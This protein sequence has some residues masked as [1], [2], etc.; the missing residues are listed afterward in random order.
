MPPRAA[1]ATRQFARTET[2]MPMKPAAADS[3]PPSAKPTATSIVCSGISTT[4][5]TTPTMPI[6]V[7]WRRRYAEAPSW[8][9][10]EIST[11]RSLPGESASSE[12]VVSAP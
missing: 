10:F 11:M 1:S 7:Y 6:V 3:T 12:R 9:A 8:T 5:R 2:F 4:N